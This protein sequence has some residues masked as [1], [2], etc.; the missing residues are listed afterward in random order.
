MATSKG[1]VEAN[2][3]ADVGGFEGGPGGCPFGG[4][5]HCSQERG[6][7]ML[8]YVSVLESCSLSLER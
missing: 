8:G 1:V 5:K 4:G 6:L 7:E 3:P 2:P